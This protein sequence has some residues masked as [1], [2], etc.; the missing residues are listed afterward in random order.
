MQEEKRKFKEVNDRESQVSRNWIRFAPWF[1]T[2]GSSVILFCLGWF[3]VENILWFR[4]SVFE[5]VLANNME[6]RIY[7]LHMHLSIL[8]RSV[9]LFS[10]FALMF[11]GTGVAFY[12][13]KS[14]TSINMGI[15][16]LSGKLITAS[17]GIIAMVLGAI[18]IIYTISS[19]DHFPSLGVSHLNDSKSSSVTLVSPDE[20]NKS[21]KQK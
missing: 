17:P 15:K 19:K 7:C 2:I 16:E 6:Y 12:S 11:V 21:N 5:H 20:L 4:R 14:R 18:I 13:L 3:L 10:G 8:K 9:G 1:L